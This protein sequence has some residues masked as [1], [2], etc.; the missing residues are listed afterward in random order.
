MFFRI[1][2]V[3]LVLA[4]GYALYEIWA[5]RNYYNFLQ[6]PEAAFTIR[7]AVGNQ[8]PVTIVEFMNYGC[9]PCKT[10]HNVLRNYADQ[11][12]EVRLVVRPIPFSN[13][14]TAETAAESVLAAGLQGKFW[15]MDRA[16][17]EY[18]GALDDKFYRETAAVYDIDY[19]RM[20][21][22]AQGDAVYKLA[23]NNVRAFEKSGASAVP[24]IMIE[25]KIYALKG[26]LTLPDLIR[27]VQ[28][29]KAR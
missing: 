21:K 28:T 10:T 26:P 6:K 3:C 7:E 8:S 2:S 24:A 25:K 20:V 12:P 14:E 19:A 9:L 11:N 27:M 13:P 29:E 18:T 15:E 17:S 16:L 22:E 4:A 5:I 1:V 23:K